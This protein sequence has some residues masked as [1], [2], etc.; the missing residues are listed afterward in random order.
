MK[1]YL[2]IGL[3]VLSLSG[4][5]SQNYYM[6]SPEGFG[7]ATTGGGNAT[8]VTV[9]TYTDLKAKLQY[10]HNKKPYVVFAVKT[11][12]KTKRYIYFTS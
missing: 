1:K 3:F 12:S 11:L 6:T 9:T 2:L 7:A 8:P 4:L 10:K 5:K